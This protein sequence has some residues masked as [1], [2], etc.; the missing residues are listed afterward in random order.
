MEKMLIA[1][2]KGKTLS[3]TQDQE[4]SIDDVL[5]R[6]EDTEFQNGVNKGIDIGRD[7]SSTMDHDSHGYRTDEARSYED[8]DLQLT[9]TSDVICNNEYF[10]V[11]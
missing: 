6:S 3:K 7:D 5:V 11:K 9:M 2:D 8:T 4:V 1:I 10:M